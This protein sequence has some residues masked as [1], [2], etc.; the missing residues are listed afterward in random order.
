RSPG[1]RRR[2]SL[3]AATV[4][5]R[6]STAGYVASPG[7]MREGRSEPHVLFIP[8]SGGRGLGEFARCVIL[9]DAIRARWSGSRIQ[10]VASRGHPLLGTQF[11]VA[12]T[13]RSPTLE[14][15]AV[16]DVIRKMGPDI[17]VFDSTCEPAQVACARALGARTV[18][19]SSRSRTVERAFCWTCLRS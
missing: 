15:P 17:V 11:D 12:W 2:T 5:S 7:P 10:L 13:E 9:G 18:F 3:V 16:C 6:S 1:V 4:E 14:S 8:V 19:I